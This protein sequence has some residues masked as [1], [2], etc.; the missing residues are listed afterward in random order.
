MLLTFIPIQP[1]QIHSRMKTQPIN[2][3]REG[4]N[5]AWIT[6]VP[7]THIYTASSPLSSR[8]RGDESLHICSIYF[9]TSHLLSTN[10]HCLLHPPLDWNSFDK[11]HHWL[12]S[13]QVR[14]TLSL[15]LY[16]CPS[17]C[18]WYCLSL[19]SWMSLPS[20]WLLE[21]H[22]PDSPAALFL[23]AFSLKVSS[24]P[25]PSVNIQYNYTQYNDQN[26][27]THIATTVLTNLEP[28]F[29]FHQLSH[30]YPFPG[31]RWMQECMLH[32]LK[33]PSFWN[34]SSLFVILT[35]FF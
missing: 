8:P 33:S 11:E 30:Y 6:S 20:L 34:S 29:K 18:I 27:E 4:R 14:W 32:I 2:L 10:F 5:Q 13:C 28:L 15:A 24:I 35:F 7:S 26:Q 3:W 9:L 12:L 31:P 19:C 16:N 21:H 17:H 22:L 1:H 25:F 23:L